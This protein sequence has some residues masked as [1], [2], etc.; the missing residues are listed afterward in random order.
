[1]KLRKIIIGLLLA[2][3][4]SPIVGGGVLAQGATDT[5]T[6]Q[7]EVFSGTFS[8]N[9]EAGTTSPFTATQPGG[10]SSGS[11]SIEV[12]DERAGGGTWFIQ[13]KT[14]K[15]TGAKTTG[16]QTF[17]ALLLWKSPVINPTN[18]VSIL[19][20]PL[21]IAQSPQTLFA[22]NAAKGKSTVSGTLEFAVPTVGSNMAPLGADTYS[23]TITVNLSGTDPS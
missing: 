8:V 23:A 11:I 3:F 7:V 16:A 12:I 20:S 14:S 10:I 1:M 6:V 17:D 22:G 4:V 2:A 9:V 5:G 13:A 15:F 18:A 19:K 21:Q